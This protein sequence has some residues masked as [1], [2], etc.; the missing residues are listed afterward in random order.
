MQYESENL[1]KQSSSDTDTLSLLEKV[2]FSTDCVDEAQKENA[3]EHFK[4]IYYKL[5]ND[6]DKIIK[7]ESTLT[8]LG[9]VFTWLINDCILGLIFAYSLIKGYGIF[10]HV[11][12]LILFTYSTG[13]LIV[14]LSN[15]ISYPWILK[16]LGKSKK[17]KI[18][19]E[20]QKQ[21]YEK[22]RSIV[23]DKQFQHTY[24]TYLQL[25]MSRYEKTINELQQKNQLQDTHMIDELKHDLIWLKNSQTGL[26]EKFVNS[27]ARLT[28]IDNLARIEQKIIDMD[29]VL[30][31]DKT[32]SEKQDDFVREHKEFLAKQGMSHLS[33]FMTLSKN[34]NANPQLD[35]N[36]EETLKVLL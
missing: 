25:H 7:H 6:N 32:L 12:A 4:D 3:F 27:D 26:I 14:S 19:K 5:E 8:L 18:K 15:E 1:K 31:P 35:I 20:N 28:V 34:N 30:N 2:I 22:I 11:M 17:L 13:G 36:H 24:L 23:K 9:S 29:I 33:S 21:Y 16:K 10:S